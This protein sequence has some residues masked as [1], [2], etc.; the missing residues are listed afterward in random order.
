[1]VFCAS[2]GYKLTGFIPGGGREQA[3]ARSAGCDC[4][5]AAAMP[6]IL[7]DPQL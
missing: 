1:M 7:P 4:V 6:Q 3:I 2:V 5:D